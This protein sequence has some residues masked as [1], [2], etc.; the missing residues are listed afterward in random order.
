MI[1]GRVFTETWGTRKTV[2]ELIEN[3]IDQIEYI[4]RQQNWSENSGTPL[5]KTSGDGSFDSTNLDDI[6]DIESSR[7]ITEYNE[8]YTDDLVKTL[9]NDFDLIN[10]QDFDGNECIDVLTRVEGESITVEIEYSDCIKKSDIKY[11]SPQEIFVEPVLNYAYDQATGVY[12]KTLKVVNISSATT[13]TADCTP[14]YNAEDGETVWET[15]KALFN[16]YK[17]IEP[18][19]SSISNTFWITE[20]ADAVN[21]VKNMLSWISKSK[22]DITV[23]YAFGRKLRIGQHINLTLPFE[24][25]AETKE[26]IIESI[27]RDKSNGIVELGLI[28]V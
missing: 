4:L 7:Q 1:K 11:P 28:I 14:G 21:K 19:P 15:C 24:T 9:C 16:K 5:I 2:G 20:Y 12:L 10:Y 8:M 26:C 18:T 25:D 17:R 6:K 3:P 27:G 22:I 23:N 13:W